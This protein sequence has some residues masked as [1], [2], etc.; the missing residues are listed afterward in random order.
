[1][2]NNLLQS[3]EA[4][5]DYAKAIYS[6]QDR[7]D[8][9]ISTSAIA[10]R[11]DVSPAS[12]TAMIKRMAVLKLVRYEP[13]K[14]V[15]LTA[16]GE[17]IAL[18][19]MRHHRLIELY[20]AK[21]LDMPWD[22]VHAEAEVLEHYISEDLEEM[23]AQKLSDPELDPHGDPIPDRSLNMP[24]EKTSVL[25]DLKPGDS[26]VFKRVSDSDPAMLRY[27]AERDILLGA[28]FVVESKEPFDGPLNVKFDGHVH[29]LGGRLA[30]S[31]RVAIS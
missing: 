10:Q 17:R 16:A 29:A 4:I 5:Q 19:T 9:L 12:A 23:I 22:G 25:A 15:S 28:K 27:L 14:G 8:G 31:M 18:E 26:G 20:L 21:A 11:V 24:H 6:L 1:M 13:Y 2:A 3:T 7:Q 30:R